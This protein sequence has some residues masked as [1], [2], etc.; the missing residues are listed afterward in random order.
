MAKMTDEK[1]DEDD[2]DGGFHHVRKSIRLE[3]NPFVP[4]PTESVVFD[5]LLEMAGARTGDVDGETFS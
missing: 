1:G 4:V 5:T 3:E 2:K